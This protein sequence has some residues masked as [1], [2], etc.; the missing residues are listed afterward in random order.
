MKNWNQSLAILMLT[1][2]SGGG[3]YWGIAF[4]YILLVFISD[5]TGATIPLRWATSFVGVVIEA[6]MLLFIL[7]M[8]KTAMA[9]MRSITED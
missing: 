9:W 6:S 5:L 3:F 8:R 7:W 2:L 4:G 1:H